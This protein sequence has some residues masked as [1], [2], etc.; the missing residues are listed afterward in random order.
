MQST[1]TRLVTARSPPRQ[2]AQ[3]I[4]LSD[5]TLRIAP[6][7]AVALADAQLLRVARTDPVPVRGDR[8]SLV[9]RLRRRLAP[10]GR[11]A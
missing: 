9:D 10:D 5:S 6:R 3:G 1:R 8:A 11:R 4:T 7:S 2:S